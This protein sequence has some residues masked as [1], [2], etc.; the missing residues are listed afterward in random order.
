M[1]R[2]SFRSLYNQSN[3]RR[4]TLNKR[5][6]RPRQA[7]RFGDEK[8]FLAPPVNRIP[9][10]GIND[11][12]RPSVMQ[13]RRDYTRTGQMKCDGTRTETRFRRPARR[14]SPFK[15]AGTSVQSA[16]GSRGVRISGS[17]AGYTM[18]RGSVKST[19]YPL[20]SPVSPSLPLPCVT[21]YHHISAGVYASPSP[22]KC[23][24]EVKPSNDGTVSWWFWYLATEWPLRDTSVGRDTVLR[25][26]AL[27]S[28]NSDP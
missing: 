1:I 15:S 14:T 12:L 25:N 13:D 27:D 4:F 23:E 16:T 26:R 11:S 10:P 2:F 19:G 24:F 20:H 5:L 22:R 6:Y 17:S 7:G 21:V 9:V 8:E 3:S 18:F 28:V